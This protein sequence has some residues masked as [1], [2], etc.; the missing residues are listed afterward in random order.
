M[1]ENAHQ[2]SI[3]VSYWRIENIMGT[4]LSGPFKSQV[5]QINN[6]S[7]LK[8]VMSELNLGG[9]GRGKG[10]GGTVATTRLAPSPKRCPRQKMHWQQANLVQESKTSNIIPG[11]QI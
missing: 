7:F 1:A 2:I 10:G 5:E 9:G 6:V 11:W 4:H 3:S 8:G